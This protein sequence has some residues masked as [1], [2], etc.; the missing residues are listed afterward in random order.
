MTEAIDCGWLAASGETGR[1]IAG[2]DWSATPLG[3][4][5]TW[6]QSLRTALGIVLRS[7]V[8]IVML[9]GPDGIMLYNDAYSGFAGGRHPQL[10]GSKVREGWA[11]VADFNDNVMRVVL[12]GGTLAYKDMELTLYRHG[13]PEQ[14]WMNLDY[15][16]V[17]DEEGRPVGVIAIVVETTERVQADRRLE[18]ERERLLQLF[19]Q[20]PG[21]I[22]SMRGPTHVVEFVNAAHRRLFGS[23]DWVGRPLRTAFRGVET[24]RLFE[25]LD[26]VFATGERFVADATPVRFE[27][28]HGGEDT[29]YLTLVFEPMRDAKGRIIGVLCEGSD[30]TEQH[31]V[32]D[33]LR[34]SEERF[35]TALEIE[36]VGAIYFDLDGRL[37]DANDAFLRMSGYS[38]DE[39]ESRELTWQKLTPDEWQ[40]DSRR[41][42]AQLLADG[43]TTPYEKEYLR[44][45][46]TRWWALFAAKLLP[47]GTGFE[48]VL[49]ITDRKAAEAALL[50]ETRTLETLNRTG[51]A[52]AGELDLEPLVQLITDAGVELTGAKYGSYFHNELD[53]TGERLHLFTLSG[54]EREQFARL[55]RP[56]ATEVFAPTFRNEG[57]IRSNDIQQ[58][59][60]YGRFEPH[61]GMPE[62]HLPVRSYLA[63]SVVSRS[64]DVLGGLLFGH[65]EP[66][67]FTERHERL[68]LGLAAQAAIAIDNARLFQAVQTSNETL[69][70]RVAERTAEL[71]QAHEALRQAQK[72]EAVG[73]LTGGIAHDFNNLLAGISGSLE[74]IERRISQG[75]T[76]DI[77]RFIGAA[78]NSAQRAAALTQR[79]LAFARRQTLDP[80]PTDVNRLV[81]GMED[82]IRRTVG[83]NIAVEVVGAGGLWLT[84]VDAAQLESALLNLAI[85]ARDAMP[86]GGRITIETANKWLDERAA[87]DRELPAGQYVSI[88][89]SDTGTGM[90]KDVVE[91][92]FD[93][94]FT[95]KP[96][97]QGTGLGLSMVHGFVRQSGGQV[98]VYSEPGEGTTMCLYLPRHFGELTSEDAVADLRIERL[99][100]GE[101]VLV[102]D[103]EPTVRM[104]IREVLEECGYS[105]IEAEDGPS[106]LRILQS[107]LPIDLLITDVGLPGGMNGRQVADAARTIRSGLKVLFVTGF[108]ENAAIGNGHLEPGMEVITK[109]FAMTDLATKISAMIEG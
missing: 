17:L 79:L 70:Q 91:R 45:D 34:R 9:W 82:L 96:I 109:P 89:V 69:E 95:T 53:E 22:I 16:P 36:T 27:Q 47:D 77:G 72:M 12:A 103:D 74:A 83:P 84:R 64:G 85:N 48:F 71:T 25:H 60:R 76:A 97:G 44:K 11:E 46:G 86:E 6:P 39:L 31:Q 93:P 56:R 35:R 57:V 28:T 30:V 37:L 18:A 5:D 80:K 14:V 75:R 73:Q 98:R 81:F 29:R 106:G 107:D 20:A 4:I 24:E 33:S 42:F 58:D 102:I 88:C 10:L 68:V 23:G 38:R 19:E 21:F 50:E 13:R 90:P 65:P 51:A 26:E 63:V 55:G 2:R 66:D 7:P 52:V 40:E 54:A 8:P 61:G 67:R 100:E 3:T 32:Q 92:I 1:L 15:S 94:F 99:G 104:L 41:A 108:A 62:G 105:A 43:E 87:H 78:Q 49:D 59:P 101:T